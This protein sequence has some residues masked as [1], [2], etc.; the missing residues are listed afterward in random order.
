ML[1]YGGLSFSAVIKSAG[2]D[3]LT[4]EVGESGTVQI[5]KFLTAQRHDTGFEHRSSFVLGANG[6]GAN[7]LNGTVQFSR[8]A[9]S[10][11][12]SYSAPVP[13]VANI[14]AGQAFPVELTVCLTLG[15][16]AVKM[17]LV[18]QGKNQGMLCHKG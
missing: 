8:I 14:R 18:C 11:T 9:D 6:V 3:P 12:F 15:D 10:Y 2:C 4:P 1:W 17:H 7:S 13:A 16:Q 5:S